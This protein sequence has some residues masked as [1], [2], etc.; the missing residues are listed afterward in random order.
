MDLLDTVVG[1]ADEG[2]GTYGVA[3]RN[4]ST[5]DTINLRADEEFDTASVVKVPIMVELFHQ[6]TWAR[7]TSK[8]EWLPKSSL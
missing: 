7:S 3:A 5:G 8:T 4:L 2:G 1:L 6:A